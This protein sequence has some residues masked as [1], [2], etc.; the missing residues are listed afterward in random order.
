VTGPR[1]V[2]FVL[3]QV[4][5]AASFCVAADID[6]AYAAAFAERPCR[7]DG[8]PMSFGHN[9]PPRVSSVWQVTIPSIDR[10]QLVLGI[11]SGLAN[12]K[13]I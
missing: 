8:K 7:P 9:Q 12:I 11:P 3:V 5:I 13:F 10:L 1:F 2:L 6:P 4:P